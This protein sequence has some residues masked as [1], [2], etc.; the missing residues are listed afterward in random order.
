[1]ELRSA[2]LE[3]EAGGNSRSF[4]VTNYNGRVLI[5][6]V[7]QPSRFVEADHGGIEHNAQR[8]L[9]HLEYRGGT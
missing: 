6:D 4:E 8:C 1:M 7:N 2:R 5:S 9:E 3:K